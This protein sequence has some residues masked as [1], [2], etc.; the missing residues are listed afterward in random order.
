MFRTTLIVFGLTGMLGGCGNAGSE[1]DEPELGRI[2]SALTS[3]Y[4]SMYLRGTNNA[5]GTTAMT[6]VSDNVWQVS[7][8]FGSS[9]SEACKF[10]VSGTWATNW[11]DNN[12]DG[13]GDPGGANIAIVNGAGAYTI[14]F[15]DSTRAYSAIKQGDATPPS[16]ALS[17]PAAGATLTGAVT[18]SADA[19][20]N[21][22]VSKVDFYA[23]TTI[24]ATDTT[25]PYSVSWSSTNLANAAYSLTAKAYDAAGNVSTSAPR[26]VTVS[27]SS[28]ASV[29]PTM[30]VR[31]THNSWG[32][33][34]MVKVATNLWQADATFGATTS[35]RFK[36]DTYANWAT[37]WGDTNHDGTCGAGETDIP[38]SGGAG[39]YRVEFNDSTKAYTVVKTSGDSTA[40]TVSL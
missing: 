27:N 10:D 18:L 9:Q 19:S 37:N 35:E 30:Y 4:P 1:H 28:Y 39:T 31:G 16:V 17:A 6:L 12:S 8:T 15:N 20:D 32:A 21:V 11:G 13:V 36:F 7:A 33:H 25:A 14:T 3:A 26:N 24:I 22:A 40:P 23:G 2:S 34:A 38:I 29:Y 5:W